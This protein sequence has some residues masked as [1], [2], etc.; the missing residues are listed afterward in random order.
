MRTRFRVLLVHNKRRKGEG[1]EEEDDD[2]QVDAAG[3]FY[4]EH[5][6]HTCVHKYLHSTYQ[7]VHLKKKE[8]K[9]RD[10]RYC[11]CILERLS[12]LLYTCVQIYIIYFFYPVFNYKKKHYFKDEIHGTVIVSFSFFFYWKEIFEVCKL[13]QKMIGQMKI[14]LK[15]KKFRIDNY[16]YSKMKIKNKKRNIK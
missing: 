3:Y 5:I 6:I 15:K 16:Q 4:N 8:K 12:T 7:Y 9:R 14:L 13:K 10:N 1:G 11:I 2:R